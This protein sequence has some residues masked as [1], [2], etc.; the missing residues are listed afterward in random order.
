MK[1]CVKCGAE[2]PLESF[3]VRMKRGVLV[4]R[5][6]CKECE[7][8]YAREARLANPAAC[9]AAVKKWQKK[10]PAKVAEHQRKIHYGISEKDY[11]GR[12]EKQAGLCAICQTVL[13]SPHVDHC[14][15]TGVFR[16]VLCGNCNT[17]LGLFKDSP[18]RLQKAIQ[19]LQK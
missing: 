5:S 7:A 4:D 12:I 11:R 9:R 2:K 17:G 8:Q 13:S 3:G 19:Y 18:D 16:G 1:T 15:K 6:Q 14:H 10:N